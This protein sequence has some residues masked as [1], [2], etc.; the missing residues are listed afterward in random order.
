M[1]TCTVNAGSTNCMSLAS[2]CS[3]YTISD[4]CVINSA[5]KLCIW[6]GTVCRNATCYDADDTTSYNTNALCLAYKAV[7]DTCTVL[8]KVGG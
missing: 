7:T 6:T 3:G 2:A 8:Y 1:N 5:N 4:Q